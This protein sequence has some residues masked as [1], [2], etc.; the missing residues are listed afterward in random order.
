MWPGRDARRRRAELVDVRELGV[1][2]PARTGA[3]FSNGSETV[4]PID[5]V[6]FIVYDR[7]GSGGEPERENHR[8]A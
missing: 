2:D 7:D 5:K 4:K 1:I 6:G 3:G 8:H